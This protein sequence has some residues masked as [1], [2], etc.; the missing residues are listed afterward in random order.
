[1][2][3]RQNLLFVVVLA[4]YSI[5]TNGSQVYLVADLKSQHFK[6]RTNENR[7]TKLK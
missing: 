2:I 3:V 5:A 7:N 1:L 6:L 4:D